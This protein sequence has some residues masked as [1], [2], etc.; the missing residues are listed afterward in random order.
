M[1]KFRY[2]VIISNPP[3]IPLKDINSLEH[4]VKE[5]DPLDALTDHGD[6]MLFYKRIFEIADHILN[7]NG[8][9]ILEFGDKIQKNNIIDIFCGYK[10]KIFNDYT[11][12]PRAITLQR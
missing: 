7:K 4:S 1:P 2:D 11:N 3:Y 5:H 8:I 6:G 10:H 12:Q 9:I